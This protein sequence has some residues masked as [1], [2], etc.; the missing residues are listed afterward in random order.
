[1]RLL[2]LLLLLACSTFFATAQNTQFEWAKQMGGPVYDYSSWHSVDQFGNVFSVGGFQNSAFFGPGVN[3]TYLDAAGSF[4]GYI[5][6]YDASGVLIW[7]KHLENTGLVDPNTITTDVDG[8]VYVA[9]TFYNMF[10]ADPG[11]GT[12]LL[13]SSTID[14]SDIFIIKLDPEGLFIWAKLLEGPENDNPFSIACDPFGNLCVVGMFEETI[15]LDPGNGTM[16]FNSVDYKDVFVLKLDPDGNYLWA[17]HS[18]GPMLDT[19]YRAKTDKLGNLFVVGSFWET[20][21]FSPG[22]GNPVFTSAGGN[23]LF[24]QKYDLDGNLE[25]MVGMGSPGTDGASAIDMDIQ[26][27]V[28][29]SGGFEQSMDFDPGVNVQ[30]LTSSGDRDMFVLKLDVDGN[31]IWVKQISGI[32]SVSGNTLTID[33]L[34]GVYICGSFE[35]TVDFDPGP[36]IYNLT[37]PDWKDAF[38]LNLNS[39]GDFQWVEHFSSNEN[40]QISCIDIDNQ[41]NIFLSGEFSSTKDFDLGTNVNE[42][43]PIGTTDGYLMKLSQCNFN[44]TLFASGTTIIANNP[45]S[46]YQ[47]LDCNDNYAPIP[48]ETNAEFTGLP[49][50]SYAM[51]YTQDVCVDTSACVDLMPV[52]TAILEDYSLVNVYPNPSQ[53]SFKISIDRTHPNVQIKLLNTVG[54]QIFSKEYSNTDILEFD[55]SLDAGLYYLELIYAN[56]ISVHPIIID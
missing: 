3:E 31:F 40:D 32:N 8:N 43:T 16:L 42:L 1:M 7:I 55:L 6:K 10:D 20:I 30:T 26:G 11:P 21:E 23:D 27:N 9:G 49:G 48:N 24:I 50:G 12:F 2:I 18:G 22:Q 46:T 41:G 5:Q 14:N 47:W 54:K 56:E 53:G 29:L 52:G 38:V 44:Q 35:N 36:A 19:P 17:H 37:P 25:W 34:G 39:D 45:N 51:Q 33:K 4:D 13:E 28:Y 15:D